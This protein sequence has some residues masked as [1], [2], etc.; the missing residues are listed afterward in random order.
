M[1]LH[2]RIQAFLNP[3]AR[4]GEIEYL[5]Q[6]LVEIDDELKQTQ[7]NER[8]LYCQLVAVNELVGKAQ[9]DAQIQRRR[10]NRLEN[11]LKNE[12]AMS[13]VM[14]RDLQNRIRAKR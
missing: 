12:R 10:A 4:Q 2:D 13:K 9:N 3:Y 5:R 11:E 1:S 8:R 14:Q 7:L 6:Q